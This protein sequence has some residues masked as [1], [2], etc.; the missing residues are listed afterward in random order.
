[1]RRRAIRIR[2]L[3]HHGATLICKVRS[4]TVTNAAFPW[5]DPIPSALLTSALSPGSTRSL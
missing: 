2:L 1:M 4:A 5:V 3:A